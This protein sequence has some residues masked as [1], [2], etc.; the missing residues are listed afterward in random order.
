MGTSMGTSINVNFHNIFPQ[1]QT[2]I[3]M[4]SS[5]PALAKP[6][7]GESNKGFQFTPGEFL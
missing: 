7:S 6:P 3:N 1:G 5:D 4:T 2:K